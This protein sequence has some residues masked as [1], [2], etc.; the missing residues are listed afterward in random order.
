MAQVHCCKNY[1]ISVGLSFGSG[2]VL[3]KTDKL[4]YCAAQGECMGIFGIFAAC[5]FDDCLCSA[6]I[7]A[8]AQDKDS[9]LEQSGAVFAVYGEL[10][11]NFTA[12]FPAVSSP[13]GE[14]DYG[15]AADDE[16]EAVLFGAFKEA[17]EETSVWFVNFN[18]DS[19]VFIV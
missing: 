14:G 5:G 15:D 17:S 1:N 8:K 6:K 11:V 4:N 10:K 18:P 3:L 13:D 7:R 2:G 19:L 16:E 9:R 12:G